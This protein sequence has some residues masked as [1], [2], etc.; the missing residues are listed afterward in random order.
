MNNLITSYS[1]FEHLLLTLLAS[2]LGLSIVKQILDVHKGLI[3]VENKTKKNK[4]IIGAK[5]T[6]ILKK[7][8]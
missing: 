1:Y 8:I 6:I 4:K 5:F 7:I 2:G 3:K